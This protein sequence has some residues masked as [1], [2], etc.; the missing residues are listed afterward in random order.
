MITRFIFLTEI[1]IRQ[2][3]LPSKDTKKNIAAVPNNRHP[4]PCRLS[5]NPESLFDSLYLIKFFPGKHLNHF[6][7]ALH[8]VYHL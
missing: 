5:S 6:E 8:T 3:S 4:D 2:Y 7:M 1:K